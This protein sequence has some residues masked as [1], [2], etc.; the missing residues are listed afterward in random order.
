MSLASWPGEAREC[1]EIARR[2]QEEAAAGIRF[3]RIAILLRSPHAYR[4]HLEEALRRA[5]IPA[6]FARGV[7]RPGPSR[8]LLA[9]LACAAERLSARR[10]AEYS[11]SARSPT[12]RARRTRWAPPDHDLAPAPPSLADAA[13]SGAEGR[14]ASPGDP[15]APSST[16]PSAPRGAGSGSWWTPP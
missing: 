7:L 15:D 8:A 12:P 4:A 1:V 11:R 6:Y 10:F 5:E 14:P 3:D 9:L 16:A 13:A 2:I